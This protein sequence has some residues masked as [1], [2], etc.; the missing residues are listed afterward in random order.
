M[1]K[2]GFTVIELLVVI[3]IIGLL[4]SIVLVS[5]KGGRER[6]RIAKSLQFA[7]TV[8]HS[9]GADA[10]GIW[11]FNENADNTCQG[12]IAPWDDICD[13]SGYNNHGQRNGATWVSG[14]TPSGTG[15]ALSFDG[16]DDYVEIP[17]LSSWRGRNLTAMLWFFPNG[18]VDDTGGSSH[19]FYP[20][21]GDGFGIVSDSSNWVWWIRTAAGRQSRS[22]SHQNQLNKWH[23]LVLT[24]NEASGDMQFYLNGTLKNNSNLGAGTSISWVSGTLRIGHGGSYATNGLIDDV[25][26][27][28]EAL[29]SA[30]I[31]QLYV[32]GAGERGLVVSTTD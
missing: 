28:T 12:A 5:L 24:Y 27:Y 10:V 7:A 2:K 31:Q 15:Y 14:N 1:K 23:H 11:D 16:V 4:S 30:Q 20:C 25:R 17:S 8:H 13:S 22:V 19:H 26:I 6:A 9:L 18:W 21:G 29:S 32:E 3:S